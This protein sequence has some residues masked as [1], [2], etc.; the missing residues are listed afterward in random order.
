MFPD[1]SPSVPEMIRSLARQHGERPAILLGERRLSY[2]EVER[3]SAALARGLLADGV[4]KG[5]RVGLLMPN[6]P[7]WLVAWLA[8]ARI[9]ALVVPI[10][11]FYQVRELYWI[12][13]HSDV[14]TLLCSARF[15]T[16]DYLERLEACAPE[17]AGQEGE[18]L[19]LP[20]L[21]YLR[22]VRTWGDGERA[23]ARPG[24]EHLAARAALAPEIDD[25]YLRQVESCVTPADPLIVIYSSGSTADPKGAVHT[26]GGMVRHSHNLN[27]FRD[28]TC[29]DRVYSPMPFFWVGGFTFALLSALHAGACL[30]CEEVFEPGN[31]LALLE[32]ERATIVAGWPH[33]AKAMREHPSF[34]TR[35]LSSIRSGNLY[36]VLPPSARPADPGLRSNSLGM[37]ETGGPHTIDD[38]SLDLPEK[39][40]GSFG[41][42]VPG[43]EHKVVD[44]ETGRTLGP[45]R[46]GEICVRGYSLM[47]GLYKVERREA[48]DA[49]GYYHTGDAGHFDSEGY[50]F[51]KGRLGDMIKTGGANVTPAEV[52]TVLCSFKEVK[53]AHVVG[54]PDPERGQ[55]VAAAVVLEPG[56]TV[57]ASALRARIKGELSAYKVPR[58]LLLFAGADLPFTDSG[59]ID[60]RSLQVLLIERIRVEKTP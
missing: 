47:L 11:T 51:F 20:S 26:H 25:D 1:Y 45:D 52:E 30:L 23:W 55:N 17:L 18:P 28:I 27:G 19:H 8:A 48:F 31:T 54:V 49:D 56:H 21:P 36:D 41:R 59:K 35:D 3:Q 33:F 7:D 46:E 32:R 58:H 9:G 6:G 42:S 4:G 10:N 39:L 44:P 60:K 12:L 29:E 15:L 5:T 53:E 43:M 13:R 50:L 22:T 34:A 57:D 14:S 37:T 2:T 24:P 40:R 38:M 16:H